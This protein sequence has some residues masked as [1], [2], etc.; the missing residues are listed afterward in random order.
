VRYRPRN[1]VPKL[2]EG[3]GR[4][5]D[6]PEVIFFIVIFIVIL[7]T[8]YHP[9]RENDEMSTPIKGTVTQSG[10]V[11]RCAQVPG[12]TR[13]GTIVSRPTVCVREADPTCDD[14]T[15]KG[16]DPVHGSDDSHEWSG[17][18]NVTPTLLFRL[19][20]NLSNTN[21]RRFRGPRHGPRGKPRWTMTGA[22]GKE[23]QITETR[24][25]KPWPR[26][27][28]LSVAGGI[29]QDLP[30]E[31]A[32]HLLAVVHAQRSLRIDFVDFPADDPWA[33]CNANDLIAQQVQSIPLRC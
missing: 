18:A 19:F 13:M 27:K 1:Q 12:I 30:T 21:S 4:F 25:E 3:S 24:Q 22:N 16:E 15:E 5:A 8:I 7:I 32:M 14:Q 2:L 11:D 23:R 31:Q 9:I 26:T 10:R 6:L 20:Q 28:L 29:A 33:E 17:I